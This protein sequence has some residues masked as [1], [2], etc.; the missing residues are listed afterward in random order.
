MKLFRVVYEEDAH[1]HTKERGV[2]EITRYTLHYAAADMQAVWD[3]TAFL[4]LPDHRT[5]I[6]IIEDAPS[7]EVL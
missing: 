4:R 3:A 1:A 2:Q 7:V 6:A 5:I